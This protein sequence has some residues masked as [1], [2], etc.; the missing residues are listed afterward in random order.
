MEALLFTLLV[1]VPAAVLYATFDK[2]ERVAVRFG[3]LPAEKTQVIDRELLR[4]KREEGQFEM[5]DECRLASLLAVAVMDAANAGP[6]KM[7]V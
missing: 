4:M 6:D 1:W 7:V 3:M 5:F 2:N